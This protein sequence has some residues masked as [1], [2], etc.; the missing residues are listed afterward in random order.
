MKAFEIQTFQGGRWKIDSV[1]DDRELAIFEAQRMDGGKRYLGVR[2]VEE[3]FDEQTQQTTTRTI[4][5]GTMTE[6]RSAPEQPKGSAAPRAGKPAAR[7]GAGETG[8]RTAAG[9][10]ETKSS[11]S[12]GLLITLLVVL[13]VL[14]L[15]GVVAIRMIATNM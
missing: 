6:T 10:T 5:K 12:I 8:Y 14:G 9:R 2:V 3:N 11:R 15:G 1:F 4:Y 13:A 7:G